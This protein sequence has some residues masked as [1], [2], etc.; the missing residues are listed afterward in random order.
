MNILGLKIIRKK[1]YDEMKNDVR[2]YMNQNYYLNCT[3]HKLEQENDNLKN[4]V[5]HLKERIKKLLDVPSLPS[6]E[7]Y[8]QL[9]SS[10]EKRFSRYNRAEEEFMNNARM[11][12]LRLRLQPQV[13]QI[14]LVYLLDWIRKG[15]VDDIELNDFAEQMAEEMTGKMKVNLME[16]IKKQIMECF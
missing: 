11:H 7:E 2:E 13:Y 12:L 3:N 1:R 15:Y 16:Q 6:I 4:I 10:V 5:E 9:D 14:E 8:Y